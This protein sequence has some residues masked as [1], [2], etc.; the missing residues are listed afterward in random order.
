MQLHAQSVSQCCILMDVYENDK[1]LQNEHEI[2]DITFN[3]NMGLFSLN[4]SSFVKLNTNPNDS[5]GGI[6]YTYT[7][8]QKNKSIK[9]K[10]NGQYE[11]TTDGRIGKYNM[12]ITLSIN[13]FERIGYLKAILP[14]SSNKNNQK[15]FIINKTDKTINITPLHNSAYQ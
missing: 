12:S 13:E 5:N 10:D 14:I 2:W 6:W 1:K 11:I 7:W 15:I 8:H 4:V 3:P 9:L